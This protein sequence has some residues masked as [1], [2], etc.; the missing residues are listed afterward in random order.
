[1]MNDEHILFENIKYQNEPNNNIS[2]F[3]Q[4]VAINK[5][6]NIKLLLLF[7]LCV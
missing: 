3:A 5:L 2:L 7:F 4:F 1:M 6:V